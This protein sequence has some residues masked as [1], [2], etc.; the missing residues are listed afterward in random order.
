ML[1]LELVDPA[2]P[3]RAAALFHQ[4]GFVALKE[5]LTPEQLEFARQGARRVV[6][7]LLAATPLEQANRGYARYS[8]GSQIHHPEWAQLVDLPTVLPVLDAIWGGQGYMCTDAGG[9]YS[10]PGARIQPLHSDVVDFFADPLGQVTCWDVPTPFIVVNFLLTEFKEINGALRCV[11]GTHRTR[12]R[13]PSLAEEPE[14]WR[15]AI[16]CAPAGTAVVRDVRG[17]HGG[18]ANNSD[19][20]RIMTSASYYAPWFRQPMGAPLPRALYEKM[21][22]RGKELCRYLVDWEGKA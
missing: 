14:H 3:Q 18:T 7:E 21:S 13:P 20:Y 16:L 9:D 4:H 11:P 19:E 12:L 8:F 6:A 1:D 5:V 17:W 15:R 2:Q 22:A 10:V